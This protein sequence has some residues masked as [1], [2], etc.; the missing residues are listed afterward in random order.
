MIVLLQQEEV[1]SWPHQPHDASD[2]ALPVD[3]L[4]HFSEEEMP[5]DE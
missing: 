3:A 5:S 4:L 1:S 2:D